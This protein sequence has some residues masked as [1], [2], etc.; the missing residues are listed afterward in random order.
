MTKV[1]DALNNRI[2]IPNSKLK[3]P[4]ILD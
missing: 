2:I 3:L 1:D 4:P